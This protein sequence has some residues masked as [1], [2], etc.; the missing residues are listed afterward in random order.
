MERV[1][2][3]QPFIR[4][5]STRDIHLVILNGTELRDEGAPWTLLFDSQSG[6]RSRAQGIPSDPNQAAGGGQGQPQQ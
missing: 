4:L 5:D 1:N 2:R 6:D 3:V